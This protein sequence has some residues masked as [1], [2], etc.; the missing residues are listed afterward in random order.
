MTYERVLRILKRNA[1]LRDLQCTAAYP[2]YDTVW[3][4]GG[5]KGYAE[6]GAYQAMIDLGIKIRKKRGVS[7]GAGNA[8]LIS[9]GYTPREMFELYERERDRLF[10]AAF[11]QTMYQDSLKAW[12][13]IF[14]GDTSGFGQLFGMFERVNGKMID[15]ATFWQQA[16]TIPNAMQ[17]MKSQSFITLERLWKSVIEKEGL[18]ASDDLEI[19]AHCMKDGEP[20]FFKGTEYPLYKAVAGSGSLPGVFAPVEHDGHLLGDGAMFHYNPT[21]GLKEPSIVIRLGRATEWPSEPMTFLDAYYLWREIHLPM[22]P[23]TQDVDCDKH[24]VVDIPCSNVAGLAFGVSKATRCA[25]IEEGYRVTYEALTKEI[26]KGR[27]IVPA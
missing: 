16:F 17:W 11:W 20:I 23:T 12:M 4:A 26:A 25:L 3:G 15:T 9:N 6:I 18:I 14:G 10:D 2:C 7:V 5:V 19:V 21:E 1:Q 22:M 24:I 13:S 27:I 8:L